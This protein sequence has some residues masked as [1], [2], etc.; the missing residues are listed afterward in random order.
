MLWRTISQ[1]S[2]KSGILRSEMYKYCDI[3][4]SCITLHDCVAEKMNFDNGV[5][6]FLFP[7]GFWITQQHPKNESDNIVRTDASKVDFQIIDEEID[8]IC[9]YVFRKNKKG[10]LIREEW[11]MIN[12]INA[13]NNGDFRVEFIT[14]YK[15]FQSVLFKC[16]VWFDRSPYHS[17]CE[18][19]LHTEK[20]AYQWKH[21]RYDCVW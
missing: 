7:H 12:F 11:E 15:S 3:E 1:M 19:I 6:S 20:A 10:K 17:E 9:I 16:W 2:A 4:D 14:Q 18:I 8:G 21:L 13:V 5:L